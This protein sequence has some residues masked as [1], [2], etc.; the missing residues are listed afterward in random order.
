MR[1]RI[2]FQSLAIGSAMYVVLP[3]CGYD[4]RGIAATRHASA[5]FSIDPLSLLCHDTAPWRIARVPPR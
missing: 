4:G 1:S 2:A 5:L 3:E